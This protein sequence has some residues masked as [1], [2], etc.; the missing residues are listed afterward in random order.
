MGKRVLLVRND[1][2]VIANFLAE[3]PEIMAF[4]IIR[5]GE[6]GIGYCL[7]IEYT[8]MVDKLPAKTRVELV[9][10]ESW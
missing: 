2:E 10:V 1:I 4:E 5:H 8:H 7:D 6:S 9:G 3:H